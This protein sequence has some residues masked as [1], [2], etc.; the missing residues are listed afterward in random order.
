MLGSAR[1][2]NVHHLELFYYVARHG[3]IS[4]AVRRM[5]YGIQQP[6]VSGQMS[7]LEEYLGGRL[8][9]RSPFQLT[10]AGV[11]L[12]AFVQPFFE[13]LDSV[14]ARLRAPAAPQLRIGAAELALRYH[15]GEVIDRLR[16]AEPKLR[17][18]L[19]SGF[20]PELEAWLEERT[21]DV[22]V[23]PLDRRPA[24][25]IHV[26]PLLRVPLVLQVP[27]A[28][29]VKSAG[30]LW[31]A[32]AVT[33]PLIGLPETESLMVR[34]RKGLDRRGVDWPTAI[35]ASSLESITAYVAKGYGFG[36]N[37]ALPEVVRHPRVRVLAL[38]GFEPLEIVALWLGEPA[39]LVR[40]FLEEARAYVRKAWP[41][42]AVGALTR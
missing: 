2:L 28:S 40:I 1:V 42:A 30:E 38:E 37:V 3:G 19:R 41:E 10:P 32:G 8:F 29:R 24:K 25:R 17:L 4:R 11:E 12:F 16:A 15:L 35:E 7:Q 39:P 34:F 20:Q 23:T 33:E 22:A 5:P 9:E 6:A 26:Q 13:N 14:E 21:V 31:A 36:V 18:G 27:K